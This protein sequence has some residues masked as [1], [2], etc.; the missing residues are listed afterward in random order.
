MG[1]PQA[2]VSDIEIG[3]LAGFFDGEGTVGLSIRPSAAKNGGPKVQPLCSMSGTEPDTLPYAVGVLE[4]AGMAFHVAWARP[5]GFAKSG[6]AYK[7]AW[8]ITMVGLN[9]TSRFLEWITPALV[10]KR[11]RAD[12]CL[13]YIAMRRAHSDFRT[14]ITV[15]E[16][17]VARQMRALNSKGQPL[18]QDV[19]FNTEKPGIDSEEARRRGM[20]GHAVRW[21][22]LT[23]D[24]RPNDPTLRLPI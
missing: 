9:R 18:T 20:R 12:L 21:G 15:E 5:A 24:T 22:Y 2:K 8:T 3:W 23:P 14:P 7:L 1:N 6:R 17:E 13:R 19:L 16:W 10:T 11:V 4:R